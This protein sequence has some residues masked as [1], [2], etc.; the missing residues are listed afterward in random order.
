M[1]ESNVEPFLRLS[2]GQMQGRRTTI[3]DI[4][5]PALDTPS[6]L[7]ADF[8]DM[9]SW[10]LTASDLQTPARE[11]FMPQQTRLDAG[12]EGVLSWALS[13]QMDLNLSVVAQ[14]V[15]ARRAQTDAFAPFGV[16][17]VSFTEPRWSVPVD[18]GV[19]FRF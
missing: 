2:Y 18:V 10:S 19:N 8:G 15:D 7:C 11:I 9:D 14:Y 4:T 6:A 13:N 12:V 16:N 1:M 17:E 5:S 3:G